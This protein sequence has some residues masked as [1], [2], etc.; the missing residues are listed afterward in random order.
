[1]DEL[2]KVLQKI[3]YITQ[4]QYDSKE[5]LE[6][7][8]SIFPYNGNSNNSKLFLMGSYTDFDILDKNCDIDLDKSDL[9]E[10]VD[11]LFSQGL[12]KNKEVKILIESK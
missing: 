3:E 11:C 5:Y 7:N 6:N 10:I 8:Y 9:S 12:L 1:M 2:I 4:M